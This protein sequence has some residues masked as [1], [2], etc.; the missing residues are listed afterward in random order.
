[1]FS[2]S[3]TLRINRRTLSSLYV[4]RTGMV[5]LLDDDADDDDDDD[6]DDPVDDADADEDDRC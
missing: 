2:F 5:C 1:M 3:S 6:A 4:Q